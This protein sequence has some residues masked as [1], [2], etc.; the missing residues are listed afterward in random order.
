MSGQFH[1]HVIPSIKEVISFQDILIW[2]TTTAVY[3]RQSLIS[4]PWSALNRLMKAVLPLVETYI[5]WTALKWD[6]LTDMVI[7][8]LNSENSQPCCHSLNCSV[9]VE[10][11]LDADMLYTVFHWPLMQLPCRVLRYERFNN[12]FVSFLH[13]VSLQEKGTLLCVSGYIIVLHKTQEIFLRLKQPQDTH[14]MKC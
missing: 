4:S 10:K 1:L 2:S 12:V 8:M 11:H 9:T 14:L 7:L 6:L 3:L 5:H 13:S